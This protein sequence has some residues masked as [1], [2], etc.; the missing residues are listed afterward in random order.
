MEMQRLVQTL[1]KTFG[2]EF[3]T[4]YAGGKLAMAEVLADRFRVESDQARAWVDEL[5]AAQAITWQGEGEAH[6]EAALGDE[7]ALRAA[8]IGQSPTPV[9]PAGEGYWQLEP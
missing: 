8:H 2:P 5:E 7:A 1:F 3:H 4:T 9:P 6:G